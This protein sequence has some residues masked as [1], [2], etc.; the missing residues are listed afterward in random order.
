MEG[1][2]LANALTTFQ[3]MWDSALPI[4]STSAP[5]AVTAATRPRRG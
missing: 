1:S 3:Q 5:F 4:S 2:Y